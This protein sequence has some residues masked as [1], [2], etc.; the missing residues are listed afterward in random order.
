MK[1]LSFIFALILLAGCSVQQRHYRK[2]YFI[3]WNKNS[4]NTDSRQAEHKVTSSEQR[5]RVSVVKE[6]RDNLLKPELKFLN[7]SHERSHVKHSEILP[8][9]SCDIILFRDG[10][11]IKARVTEISSTQIKYKRC[12]RMDGPLYT[13]NKST[14][15]MLTYS[16]GSK[17]VFK[18]RVPATVTR[19]TYG[20]ANVR[21]AHSKK[22]TALATSALVFSILGFY[23]LL[24]LGGITGIILS[25]IQLNKI[26]TE[27]ET[28]GAENKSYIALIL[29]IVTVITSAFFVFVSFRI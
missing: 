1:S 27:P 10:S 9:D 5:L 24:F 12:D 3:S 16:N 28:Y 21:G 25:L 8:D 29:G 4:E 23:P 18:D 26:A 22:K 6:D 20:K 13:A 11:E 7:S 17:E 19:E 2:G 15:F 14:I